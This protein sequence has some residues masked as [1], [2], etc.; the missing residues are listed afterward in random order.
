M[1]GKETDRVVRLVGR[2]NLI[3]TSIPIIV[4]VHLHVH[5]WWWRDDKKD[6]RGWGWNVLSNAAT[7]MAHNKPHPIAG[8]LDNGYLR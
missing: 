2:S 7:P 6:N 8:T 5:A 4:E 1:G 3:I